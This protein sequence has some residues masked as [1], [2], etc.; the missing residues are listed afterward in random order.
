MMHSA[1]SSCFWEAARAKR[2][3]GEL[4]VGSSTQSSDT[5]EAL[6]GPG[7]EAEVT[8]SPVRVPR[9]AARGLRWRSAGGAAAAAA[10]RAADARSRVG[11]G[12]LGRVRAQRIEC[13]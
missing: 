5:Y 6:E 11:S 12:C 1:D 4:A 8:S 9:P 7:A 10:C 3:R 2:E 13:G